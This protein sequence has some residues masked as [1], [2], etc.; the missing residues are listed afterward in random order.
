MGLH[1]A[2]PECSNS[3]A[4]ATRGASP[5][6]AGSR[7]EAEVS[8]WVLIGNF[9]LRE[10]I[11]AQGDGKV[12]PGVE[13]RIRN[14]RDIRNVERRFFAEERDENGIPRVVEVKRKRIMHMEGEFVNESADP[15]KEVDGT[16]S[17]VRA[18][19]ARTSEGL[20]LTPA[21]FLK[22]AYPYVG[23]GNGGTRSWLQA[24][25]I[26]LGIVTYC[27]YVISADNLE[28]I[29][30][31]L[32]EIAG[33]K[34]AVVTMVSKKMDGLLTANSKQ[35]G[36]ATYLLGDRGLA[37]VGSFGP[38]AFS[39]AFDMFHS[40]L[41]DVELDAV[42]RFREREEKKKVAD[43]RQQIFMLVDYGNGDFNFHSNKIPLSTFKV[44]NYV[45]EN[46]KWMSRLKEGLFSP[47]STGRLT[48]LQGPAGTGKTRFLR[49]LMQELGEGTVSIVL[50]VSLAGELSQP[51]MLGQ[52]TANDDFENK[53]LLLIIEDGDGLLEKRDRASSVIS[54]FLNI[55]DGLIGEIVNLH[56]IVT[57]NLQKKDFDPAITR[58]GRLHSILYFE[59]LP[60]EQAAQVYRRE[61]GEDLNKD[62][63]ESTLAEIYALVNNHANGVREKKAMESG[64]YL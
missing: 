58:P 37:F 27:G 1:K 54:D 38:S 21:E 24:A 11:L 32:E 29:E 2:Q 42:K 51:R 45:E 52:I 7:G 15:G 6:L 57:T 8:W 23:Q 62:K 60:Y 39:C 33:D 30:T 44:E 53:N 35:S 36:E 50:P 48:I 59:A 55:V 43:D 10:L 31:F 41:T 46:V 12:Q 14:Y 25:M 20:L 13:L 56:V 64:Q 34:L 22:Q 5:A 17:T 49:A 9:C 18:L 63:E 61:T 3:S 19:R 26:G 40:D 4:S 28:N 16:N 47:T